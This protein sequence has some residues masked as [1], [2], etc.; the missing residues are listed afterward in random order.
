MD[1]GTVSPFGTFEGVQDEGTV[2]VMMDVG[3]ENLHLVS[4]T[5]K[6]GIYRSGIDEGRLIGD[7]EAE[8]LW[9]RID[10]EVMK[11]AKCEVRIESRCVR[12]SRGCVNGHSQKDGALM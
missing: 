9:R 11:L 8:C 10:V 3:K 4:Y 12:G 7:E 5:R 6:I 1:R 2:P